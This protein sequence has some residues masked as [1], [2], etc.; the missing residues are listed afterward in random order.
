MGH[1]P[2]ARVPVAC[3]RCRPAWVWREFCCIH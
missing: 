2:A 3:S 1:N